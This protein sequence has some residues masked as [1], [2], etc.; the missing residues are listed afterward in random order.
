MES[1]GTECS[2]TI[3]NVM[4]NIILVNYDINVCRLLILAWLN[5]SKMMGFSAA[6]VLQIECKEHLATLHQST[7]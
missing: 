7:Q 3:L 4:I 5:T 1:K 6:Q 2:S